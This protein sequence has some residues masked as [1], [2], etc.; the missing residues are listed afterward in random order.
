MQN[1]SAHIIVFGN[2]KGGSGKSTAAMHVAVALL[3]L[4]YRVGTID[5]DARQGTLSRYMANRWALVQ[6]HNLNIPSPIHMSIERS[7]ADSVLDQRV[8]ERTFLLQALS[9]MAPKQDFIIIDT[10]GNDSYLSQLAHSFANTLVTPMNDSYIDLDVIARTDPVT[11]KYLGP[12]IYTKMVQEQMERK[13]IRAK[14][15]DRGT[16]DIRWIVMRNRLS[17]LNIPAK[18]KMGKFMQELG[19][20]LGFTPID[21]FCERLVFREMFAKGLTLLD[22]KS[23]S[24]KA[25]S[26]SHVSA[27]QEVRNLIH[28]IAPQKFKPQ[29]RV[30]QQKTA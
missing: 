1:Q 4:G 23:D 14:Y 18:A 7:R 15:L 30:Q 20:K 25:M 16:P 29:I 3:R 11:G 5:L 6:Q 9:E 27:R 10:P 8:E 24:S 13:A 17:P 2:E 12:S 28:A 21:G 26:L 19:E 22:M